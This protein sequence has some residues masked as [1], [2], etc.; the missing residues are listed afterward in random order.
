MLRKETISKE[1]YDYLMNH[2]F[3]F[4][5]E[6]FIARSEDEKSVYKLYHFGVT[7]EER[8]NKEQ[9]L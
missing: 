6:G 1:L 5:S 4:G 3:E 2:Y 9:K 8:K 7:E